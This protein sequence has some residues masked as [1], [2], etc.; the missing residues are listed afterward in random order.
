MRNYLLL[1]SLLATGVGVS[2]QQL[3]HR[4]SKPA[5]IL[6]ERPVVLTNNQSA[7]HHTPT[8][9]HQHN[10]SRALT[11]ILNSQRIGSAGNLLTV[12]EGTC[13]QI[14]VNESLNLVFQRI[15]E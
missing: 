3:S 12:L 5:N 10:S 9:N 8:T 14:D 11:S 15:N 7:A 1:L 13:N 4:D 6:V 2:A